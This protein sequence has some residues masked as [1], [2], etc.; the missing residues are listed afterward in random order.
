MTRPLSFVLA[1]LVALSL[2]AMTPLVAAEEVYTVDDNTQ[3]D[4]RDVI[5]QYGEDGVAS[6]AVNGLDMSITVSDDRRKAGI[7][8]RT[9]GVMHTYIQVE[10]REDVDRTVRFYVPSEYIQ[11]RLKEGLQAENSDA[12]AML[13]PVAGGEYTAVTIQFRE[14]T[15]ATFALNDAFGMYL[16][17][18]DRAY[19]TIENVTGYTMPRLGAK[20]HEQWQYPPDGALVGE[21]ATYHIPVDPEKNDSMDMTIQYD[22]TPNSEEASWL[23]VKSCD[24]QVEPV[25]VTERDGEPVLFSGTGEAVPPIRYKHG[26]DRVSEA[27]S[28]WEE[29]KDSWSGLFDNVSGLFGTVMLP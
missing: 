9:P 2:V 16:S 24:Q 4:D 23:A 20:G 11:P 15:N 12:E 27:K 10:Y 17:T 8:A 18:T 28:G 7:D 1:V 5:A 21:N 29:L 26:K 25:C 6:T 13:E 14:A 19:S 22:N 3:L